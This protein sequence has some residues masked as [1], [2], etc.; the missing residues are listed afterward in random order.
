MKPS[1]NEASQKEKI[2][3]GSMSTIKTKPISRMKKRFWLL[4]VALIWQI[5]L[6]SFAQSVTVDS[7]GLVPL[8]L[9]VNISSGEY[10]LP[11]TITISASSSD[12][13][14]VAGFLKEYL[15]YLGK[16]VNVTSD[17]NATIKLIAT[18]KSV[19][20]VEGYELEVNNDGITINASSGAGLFYGVQTLIQLLPV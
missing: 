12:E 5:N 8:P 18:D 2:A 11:N 16:N 15:E 17:N 7:L 10:T 20:N 9:N 3:D 19:A 1:C 4:L 14:N 6:Q 13:T